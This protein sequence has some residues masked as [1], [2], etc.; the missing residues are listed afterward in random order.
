MSEKHT[1]ER[2]DSFV[3]AVVGKHLT[4]KELTA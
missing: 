2:L 1:L 3:V 4:Y